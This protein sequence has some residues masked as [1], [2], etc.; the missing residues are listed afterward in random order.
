MSELKSHYVYILKCSDETLYTGYTNNLAK[1]LKVHADGKGAKYTRARLPVS[2]QYIEEHDSKSSALKREYEI[3]Q[4]T[5]KNKLKL[6]NEYN[7]IS[8]K[9]NEPK[10]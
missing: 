5:R 2:L 1:R 6:I 9:K 7:A 8:S 10:L 4:L 3:K